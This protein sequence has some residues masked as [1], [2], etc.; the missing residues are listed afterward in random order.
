MCGGI[1]PLPQ[2]ASMVWYSVQRKSTGTTLPL[3]YRKVNNEPSLYWDHTK[4]FIAV[5]ELFPLIELP[6]TTF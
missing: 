1:P 4:I 2:Y 5:R 3:P 6:H